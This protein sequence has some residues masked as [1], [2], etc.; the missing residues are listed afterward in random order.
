MQFLVFLF[1]VC[2]V[3]V[4]ACLRSAEFQSSKSPT[5]GWAVFQK[6]EILFCYLNT[7]EKNQMCFVFK[8]T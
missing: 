6:L 7:F 2:Y 8:Y 3:A 4:C 1:L 5:K